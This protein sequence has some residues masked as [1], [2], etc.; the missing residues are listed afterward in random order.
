M[1]F[2]YSAPDML[3]VN[4]KRKTGR[5]SEHLSTL[6]FMDFLDYSWKSIT[7]YGKI[8]ESAKTGRRIIVP[9]PENPQANMIKPAEN[10][11]IK[12]EKLLQ[13]EKIVLYYEQS[14]ST[15]KR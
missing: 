1:R 8:V 14:V 10:I 11:V 7:P 13:I 6:C 3:I 12:I 2:L 9:K 5:D 4:G 15:A